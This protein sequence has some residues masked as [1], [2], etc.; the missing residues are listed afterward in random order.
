LAAV[1]ATGVSMSQKD[2]A[3]EFLQAVA[4]GDA[5]GGVL[6]HPDDLRALRLPDP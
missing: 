2:A 6:D 4:S 5:S 3:L 1:T